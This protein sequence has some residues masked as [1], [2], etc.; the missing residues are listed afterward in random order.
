MWQFQSIQ[1]PL[2]VKDCVS[3][4]VTN[5]ILGNSVLS[6][7]LQTK[8]NKKKTNLI[9][10]RNRKLIMSTP[11]SCNDGSQGTNNHYLLKKDKDHKQYE[12]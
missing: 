7:F 11:E 6:F 12:K 10:K 8:K 2:L 5:A 9:F 3:G 1:F 4:F